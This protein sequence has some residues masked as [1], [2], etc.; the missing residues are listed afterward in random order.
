MKAISIRQP[1]AWLILNAG[2]DIE[3]RKWRTW[4]RGRVLVHAS[5]GL[6]RRE[7]NAAVESL[8]PLFLDDCI[9]HIDFP[10][11]EAI[12]RGGIVGSVEIVDC[13]SRSPSPWFEGPFGFQL[14]KPEQLPFTPYKG[15]LGFFDVP[16]E[17]VPPSACKVCG[18]T[19]SNACPGGCH[20][21]G[22]GLCSSCAE[23]GMSS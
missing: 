20:W 11:F 23:G 9:D 10:A 18:C 8:F 2:K 12:E 1:W 7:Y 5:S 13:V 22:P 15:A 21:V 3:N 19:W 16:D 17:T 14:A 4:Q 6:T